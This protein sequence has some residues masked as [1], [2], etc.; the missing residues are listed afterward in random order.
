MK[1]KVLSFLFIVLFGI[2]IFLIFYFNSDTKNDIEEGLIINEIISNNKHSYPNKN[3]EYYD[4][5]E[6]Y[7]DNDY[8]INLGGFY[9]SD[10]KN[11]LRKFEFP[12]VIIN[13]KDYLI[14][15]ASGENY[16]DEDEIHT[17]FKLNNNGETLIL[18]DNSLNVLSKI[19]YKETMYD[20]SYGYNESEYVYFYNSTPNAKNTGEYSINPIKKEISNTKIKISNYEDKKLELYNDEDKDI[21]LDN[22][23][24]SNNLNDLYYNKISNIVIKAKDKAIIDFDIENSNTIILSNNKKEEIDR[25]TI[26]HDN[27]K[28][29]I[30]NEVSATPSSFIELKNITNNDIS[31]KDYEISD[32]KEIK[33]ALDNVVIR[34]NSYYVLYPDKLGFSINNSNEV[35]TL[36]KGEEVI[37]TFNVSK[38]NDGIS[39]GINDLGNRVYYK[40]ITMGSDNSNNYYLG[41][42]LVPYFSLDGG[43][44]EK[45]SN[46]SLKTNNDSEIYYTIDGSM[47]NR[48]SLKYENDITIDKT[49]TIK[50]IS[51]KDNYLESD[52]VSRT[53]FTDRRHTLPVVSISTESYNL[54][55]SSGIITNYRQDSERVVSFEFYEK[56]G[57]LGTSFVSGIKLSGMDSRERDQ[58]SISVYLRKRYGLKE[59][60][61]PFFNDTTPKTYSSF[62]LRNSGEDPFRVRIM[63][64]VL[65][66]TLDGMNIDKQDYRPVVLY[67]NGEYYGLYNLREKLNSDYVVTNFEYE[68]D[69]IDV[70]KY[71]TP[72]HGTISNFNE[73]VSYISNNDVTKTS[74]YE[75][76]KSKIDIEELINYVIVEAYYG[77]TDLGNIRYWKSSENDKWRFMLYDLDWSLW[78]TNISFAYPI[79]SE[80]IP[81]ATYLPSVYTITKKLYQNSEFRDLYLKSIASALKNNFNKDKMC[82]LVDELS[83]EIKDEIPYHIAKWKDIKS[84]DSWQSNLSR[85]KNAIKLRYDTV[86][87]RLKSEFNLSSEEYNKYFGDL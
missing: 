60:S 55:G 10:N 32:N 82:D 78:N 73:I 20:T 31:L 80:Q 52:V 79:N 33:V 67:L 3:L 22:Y 62:L 24:I 37:D 46:V 9:L 39:T 50:A 69:G 14:V 74:V 75:Y 44:I 23:Y 28:S 38:L 77:N 8:D 85:F 49:M 7:N 29:I 70:I 30:I 61:Y 65:T 12:S 17:N 40:D 21:N 19:T 71:R 2:G 86:V 64:A 66:K 16:Y 42:S 59:V 63:D 27:L 87:N 13:S 26:N 34:A 41:Y 25:V 72:T 1:S 18:S 4:I 35:L 43:Y 83:L 15:Y 76:I 47:P 81:A 54:F 57:S 45:G 11:D 51:Y 48:N 6:L 58:K 84:Y 5:I 53:F 56:N 68:K 36:Y